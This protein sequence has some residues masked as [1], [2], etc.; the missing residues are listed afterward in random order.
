MYMW[1]CFLFAS[2]TYTWSSFIYVYLYYGLFSSMY[3]MCMSLNMQSL[4]ELIVQPQPS[5]TAGH[6]HRATTHSNRAHREVSAQSMFA[7]MLLKWFFCLVLHFVFS[8][9]T[10][11]VIQL[12]S[13]RFCL[14]CL[15]LLAIR[16]SILILPYTTVRH[17]NTGVCIGIDPWYTLYIFRPFDL[18]CCRSIG[19]I[20]ASWC[21]LHIALIMLTKTWICVDKI[22]HKIIACLAIVLLNLSLGPDAS[23]FVSD[24]FTGSV[25][26]IKIYCPCQL[27]NQLD[28]FDY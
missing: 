5:H 8:I 24:E 20:D 10:K 27:V 16:H 4:L 6:T 21:S 14:Q 11:V 19:S 12:L 7:C 3:C 26:G 28:T 1:R 22:M 18:Q 9:V 25:S 13:L 23:A 2:Y 17:R 15:S